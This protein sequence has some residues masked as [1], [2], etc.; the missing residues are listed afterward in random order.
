MA[1]V[2]ADWSITRNAALLDLR[3]IGAAHTGA[4]SYSTTIELHRGLADLADNEDE[5]GDDQLSIITQTPSDRGGADTNISLLNGCNIDDASSEHIYD[6]SITQDG[7]N[8]IF[9]GIQV[10]GNSAN[11]QVIQDG[12]RVVNDFWNYANMITATEDALSS[13]SHRFVIPVRAGG[14][15]IDGRRLLGTQRELGTV[16]TEFFIGG[17]TNRGNNVLALTGNSDGNNQTIAG[18]IETWDTIVNQNEGYIGID[19]NGDL[20]DEFYYSRWTIAALTKN[21]LYERAKWI[22]TRVADIAVDTPARDADQ[23]IYGLPGDI[24]RGITHEIDVDNHLVAAFVEPESLSW[25]TGVTAGTG[26]L[27]ACDDVT[28][29]NATKLWIQLLSGVAPTDGLEITGN[30]GATCD[31]NTTVTP[32]LLAA[33]FIGT[34]TGSAINTGAYGIGI[35]A[36]DLTQN[37]KLV[38]L[39]NTERTPPNNVTYTVS[40]VVVGDRIL[41][42]N[43]D[44]GDIDFAQMVTNAAYS[45]A[46]SAI[47]STTAI[48]VDTPTTGTIRL[49]LDDGSYQR[50]DYSAYTGSTFTVSDTL[51]DDA[52]SGNNLFISYIDKVVDTVPETVTWVYDADRTVFTRVRNAVAGGSPDIKTFETTATVGTGGGSS[53]VGR[54]DDF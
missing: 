11:I 33:C 14:T 39:T 15:D 24:F 17:G 27:L 50:I 51:N 54:I 21:N 30:G 44:A 12:A 32:R 45:G 31:V 40:N 49:E 22:Q 1:F 52:A 36:T 10:F 9:D 23:T 6:G 8:D 2:L 7:G 35:L 3:Y 19:A 20:A 29:G 13:T 25:G 48:P 43:N 41:V 28:Q 34:S 16:Y 37:D 42:T 26:Q 46:V 5:V 18:T 47:V 38:D 4:A 53:T